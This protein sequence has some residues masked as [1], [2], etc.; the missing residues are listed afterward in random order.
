MRMVRAPIFY[1]NMCRTAPYSHWGRSTLIQES[2]TL[3]PRIQRHAAQTI[4]IA[5][6]I[7]TYLQV[8]Y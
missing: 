2:V 5:T 3:P 8:Y 4:V 7:F 6:L 1:L